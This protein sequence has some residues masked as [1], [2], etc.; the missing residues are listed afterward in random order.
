M[1]DESQITEDQAKA[2]LEEE[3]KKRVD[4]CKKELEEV[5]KKHNCTLDVAIVVSQSGNTPII[6][7]RAL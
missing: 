6:N 1:A 3:K 4:A 5:T 7:V 2:L